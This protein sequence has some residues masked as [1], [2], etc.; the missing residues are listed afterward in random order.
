MPPQA[1]VERSYDLILQPE[2]LTGIDRED[3]TTEAKTLYDMMT[4]STFTDPII[5]ATLD[6]I[7]REI[8]DQKTVPSIAIGQ[9]IS[10]TK[11]PEEETAFLTCRW[12]PGQRP[13]QQ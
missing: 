8:D 10:T 7:G 9:S 2:D 3:L 11:Y 12:S 4:A 13:R 6:S 1:T 5:K